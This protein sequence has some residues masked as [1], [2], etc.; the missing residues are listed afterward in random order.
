MRVVLD[1]NILVRAAKNATGPA[2]ELLRS[3]E[4]ED[5]VLVLSSFILIELLRVLDYPRVRA[6]H[7]LRTCLQI[8]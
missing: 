3:F 5:H 8:V 7:R 1:T 4:S 6:L 2:R